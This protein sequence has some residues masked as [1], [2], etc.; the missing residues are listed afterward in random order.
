MKPHFFT[1]STLASSSFIKLDDA[2]VHVDDVDV[3]D[4]DGDGDRVM[5]EVSMTVF[6]QSFS[7]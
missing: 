5:N 4:N 3:D 6:L 1:V 7:P 2:D